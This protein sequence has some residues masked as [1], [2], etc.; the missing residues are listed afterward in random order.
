MCG[1]AGIVDRCGGANYEC[2]PKILQR[3]HHRGPDDY[4]ILRF[5]RGEVQLSRKWT[6]YQSAPEAVF[7]HRRLSILDLSESGWQPMGTADGRYYVTFNGEIY[8]YVELR[9]ELQALGHQFRSQSDTEV[10]LAAWAEWGLNALNRFVGMFAFALLDTQTRTLV[11]AR[12]FFGIKPFYYTASRDC[13]AFASE[14]KALLEFGVASRQI[15]RDRLL[16]YLRY[17]ACKFGSAT[18]FADI[19]QLPPAHYLTLSLDGDFD[20]DPVCYWKPVTETNHDISFEEAASHVRDLFLNNVRIHL[21]SDVPVGAALSGGIDSSAIV[22]AMRQIDSKLQLHTF[23]YVA[24]DQAVSEEHWADLVASAAH[25]EVHKTRPNAN[26]LVAD[27]SGLID[28]QD[29]PVR[30]TSMYAQYCVFRAAQ[31]AGIKVMLDG[32]GSDEMFGGYR[33][34]MGARLASLLRQGQWT[35]AAQFLAK[36]SR[37]PGVGK[38]WLVFIA[39]EHL[40][41]PEMHLVLRKLIGK[42]PNPPWLRRSWFPHNATGEVKGY[43]YSSELLKQRLV[44]T[45]FE[46][47]LANLLRYEDRNSMAFSIESRVPFLTPQ[48][49]SF[50]L[51]L[52]E[53]YIIS[54]DGLSKAVFR[55]AMRGIVPDPILDRRDKVGFAT[56]EEKW[57]PGLSDWVNRVLSSEAAESIPFMDMKLIRGEWNAIQHGRK[58]FDPMVWRWINLIQWTQQFQIKYQ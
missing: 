40:L 43:G 30:N 3:L 35:Q 39:G 48:L 28:A 5:A 13:F 21:R 34:Y 47:N 24:D 33:F 37:Y 25:S 7:L 42:N 46:S 36:C 9:A 4:G 10:L 53:H 14:M 45:M 55:R 52:P 23:T 1:I 58:P 17:G 44:Q 12:D 16:Q 19:H 51:S 29:E 20:A 50:V 38:L 57:L 54:N 2:V 49:V 31:Q 22:M 18:M 27:L 56:P 6:P 32:Q 41:P 15:D 11:C 26:T 8:N